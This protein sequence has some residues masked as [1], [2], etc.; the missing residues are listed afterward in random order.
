MNGTIAEPSSTALWLQVQWYTQA[1]ALSF[2]RTENLTLFCHSL[3]LA[4]LHSTSVLLADL[5]RDLLLKFT[6]ILLYCICS[7]LPLNFIF[8]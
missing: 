4:D 2:I 1:S 7:G 3:E 8:S 6:L 5:T